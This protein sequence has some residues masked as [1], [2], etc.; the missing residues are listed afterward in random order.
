MST[1]GEITG[2]AR[3]SESRAAEEPAGKPE[4]EPAVTPDE[5]YA[6]T[7]ATFAAMTGDLPTPSRPVLVRRPRLGSR[8][9]RI[10]V[11]VVGTAVVMAVVAGIVVTYGAADPYPVAADGRLHTIGPEVTQPEV[12]P[13]DGTDT[14]EGIV[15]SDHLVTVC[16]ENTPGVVG[17]EPSVAVTS[18][19]DAAWKR[20]ETW[21]AARAPTDTAALGQPATAARIDAAQKRMSV[22]FPPDLVA[23]LRRHD[24]LAD[25][26]VVTLPPFYLPLGVT[27]I[28]RSWQTS[29]SVLTTMMDEESPETGWLGTG[30]PW[31]HPQ[32][33]PFA[34]SVDGG[35]LVADQRPGG[36]GRVGDFYAEQGV[37][38]ADWPASITELLEG[39]ATSLETGTPY[40]G[41]Y[42]PYVGVDGHLNWEIIEDRPG[43]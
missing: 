26:G 15:T 38:F 12:T 25:R 28:V 18:R 22:A 20:I 42:R 9:K 6:D 36:H 11:G 3:M 30:E 13:P 27:E 39:T 19:V 4:G 31:W 37:S 21:L 10:M 35:S 23:S 32:Y 29:C 17:S 5:V 40:A 43:T 7:E 41:R 1:L 2:E 33:V 24:G 16:S 14:S 34:G 8:T